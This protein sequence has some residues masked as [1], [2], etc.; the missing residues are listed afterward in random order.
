MY[1]KFAVVIPEEASAIYGDSINKFPQS[2]SLGKPQEAI[3]GLS[4]TPHKS[5]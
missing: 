4:Q 2:E 3:L 5:A 1:V